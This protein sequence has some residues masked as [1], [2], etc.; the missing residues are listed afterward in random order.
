[1]TE[2]WAPFASPRPP[3]GQAANKHGGYSSSEPHR[4]GG[5]VVHSMGGSLAAGLGELD[6]IERRASWTFSSPKAGWLLQH[7]PLNLDTWASGS[8]EANIHFTS[9]EHEGGPP[10]NDSEPLTE[11]QIANLVTLIKWLA[12]VQAWPATRRLHELIEHREAVAV[13]GGGATACPSGRI[14]WN[15]ILRRLSETEQEDDMQLLG[16]YADKIPWTNSYLVFAD[17]SGN[18][19]KAAVKSAAE[20]ELLVAAG[21]PTKAFPKIGEIADA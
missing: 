5:I 6:K 16:Q 15:E 8:A 7:F 14:P 20:Y 3:V 10:G 21:Y 4:K 18:V 1:M 13:Y 11:N 2:L 12:D 9:V 17:A 19:K